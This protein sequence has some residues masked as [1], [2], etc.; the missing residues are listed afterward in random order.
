MSLSSSRQLG[1]GDDQAWYADLTEH[2]DVEP[3]PGPELE[4]P[5]R[6]T[7]KVLCSWW[8]HGRAFLSEAASEQVDVLVVQ[9]H[10]LLHQGR[11]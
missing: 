2:D 4:Q 8:T 6:L 10:Q 7:Y 3:H 5:P 1:A 9:E 11:G